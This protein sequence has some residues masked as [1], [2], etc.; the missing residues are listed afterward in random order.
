MKKF[1]VVALVSCLYFAVQPAF[2]CDCSPIYL[3]R[4]KAERVREY[5][6]NSEL[7]FIGEA[8][9]GE[10]A[11]YGIK[12]LDVFKGDITP[13]TVLYGVSQSSCSQS[14]GEGIWIVYTSVLPD[15][16][17]DLELCSLTRSITDPYL[18]T[19][20]PLPPPELGINYDSLMDEVNDHRQ[21]EL[22]VFLKNW[23]AEYAML[24]AYRNNSAKSI[25]E[26]EDKSGYL[27]YIAVGLALIALI[28]ALL[29]KK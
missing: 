7:V 25:A 23:S 2:A 3:S 1:A 13:G 24:V 21:E 29:R 19:P 11:K 8:F 4:W 22:G 20:P 15:G 18:F 6:N 16:L 10:N 14:A 26:Q 17:I 28:V 9:T 5:V 27:T 12:V